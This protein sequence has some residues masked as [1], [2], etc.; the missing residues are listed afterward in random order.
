MRDLT[1]KW[2]I[3]NGWFGRKTIMAEVRKKD[4]CH[5]DGT[6]S[7]EYRTYQKATDSDLMELEIRIV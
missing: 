4:W 5:R 7:P 3:K 2:Y 1:G 6:F